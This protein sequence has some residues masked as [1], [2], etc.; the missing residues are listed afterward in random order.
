MN[1]K[2]QSLATCN[3][4]YCTGQYNKALNLLTQIVKIYPEETLAK[5]LMRAIIESSVVENGAYSI[6]GIENNRDNFFDHFGINWTGESLENKTITVFSDQGMGD[7]LNMLRYLKELKQKWNCTIYLNCYSYFKEFKEFFEQIN[8][9]D[10]FVNDYIKTDYHTNIFSI[11]SILNNFDYE[12]HYPAHF[13]DLLKTQIPNHILSI[14][15]PVKYVGVKVGLAWKSNSK[16]FLAENKSI[17]LNYFKHFDMKFCSLLPEKVDCDFLIQPEIN[18]VMD[19]VALIKGLDV[20][21]SVDTMVLHLS[22]LLNKKTL[23]LLPEQHDPRWGAEVDCPWYPSVKLYRNQSNWEKL[24]SLIK[25][26][27]F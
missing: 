18:T 24:L 16:N 23:G 9:I 13:K 20:V 10:Y 26:E 8:F 3:N 2:M 7:L 22:G 1:L 25:R 12:I 6:L 11:A 14:N 15:H 5:D 21:V 4:Y 17:D 27:A 19:T